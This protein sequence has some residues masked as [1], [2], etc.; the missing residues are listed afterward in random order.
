MNIE[1]LILFPEL[2]R[3]DSTGSLKKF[4]PHNDNDD[5]RLAQIDIG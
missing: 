5:V 2:F 1:L 4:M 3:N